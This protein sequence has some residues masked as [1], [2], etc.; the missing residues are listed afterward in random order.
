MQEVEDVTKLADDALGKLKKV[1]DEDLAN[2]NKT[3][4]QAGMPH[5]RILAP[6][7][8]HDAEEDSEQE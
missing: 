7:A 1:V 3:M 2:L 8:R 6:A 5:I 4:N